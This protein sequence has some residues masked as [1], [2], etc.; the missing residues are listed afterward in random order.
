M[1][2]IYQNQV[3]YFLRTMVIKP[4]TRPH[5]HT[6]MHT[7]GPLSYKKIFPCCPNEKFLIARK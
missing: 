7:S 4:K 3:F 6:G 2:D 5:T 1:A